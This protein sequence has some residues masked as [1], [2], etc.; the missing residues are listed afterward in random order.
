MKEYLDNT[1]KYKEICKEHEENVER[2]KEYEEIIEN[3]E[4]V[5]EYRCK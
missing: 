4:E 1:K 2:T 5:S 3:N